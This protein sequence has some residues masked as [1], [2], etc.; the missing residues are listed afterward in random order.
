M[1]IG[2]KILLRVSGILLLAAL[3]Q[4]VGT[5]NPSPAIPTLTAVLHTLYYFIR[6]GTFA[7]HAAASLN[8]ILRGIGIS[9]LFGFGLGVL[10]FR[11]A[12][13]RAAALPV[14]E[15]VRGVAA[16]TLFPL[17]IV[18]FG[19]GTFSRVF[20]IFWTAWP[21][22]VLSTL[23]SLQIDESVA[24]AARTSGASE[25]R[26]IFC[27]RIPMAAQGIFTGL[28]IGVGAGWISLVAAEMLGATRG[29]GYFLLWS[30][31][32]FQFERVY[33]TIIVIAAIG[34]IMN[35][36]LLFVQNKILKSIGVV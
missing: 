12:G 2:R 19:L 35:G 34:G 25:W 4:V 21:A 22:G 6:D 20:I 7:R 27:I 1:Q 18:L 15:S 13:L 5:F 11:Y 36:I 3:W 9:S 14:V 33:A 28:R 24:D 10:M 32:S 8:I 29:L 26:V 17:L 30:A 23:A 31:Q 16:L